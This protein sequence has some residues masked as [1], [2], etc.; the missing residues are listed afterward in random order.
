MRRA[1]T[2][3][4]LALAI[5][6]APTVPLWARQAG[7]EAEHADRP[8]AV[9]LMTNS[10]HLLT[11]FADSNASTCTA[12]AAGVARFSTAPTRTE[13]DTFGP[14]EVPADR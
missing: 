14:L 13:R 6:D 11:F 9:L 1:G 5:R 12:G 3:R 10:P 8:D 7:A 2:A 4:L